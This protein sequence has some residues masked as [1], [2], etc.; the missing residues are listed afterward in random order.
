MDEQH[1]ARRRR[2][3]EAGGPACRDADPGLFFP[4]DGG[5]MTSG[6][7]SRAKALCQACPVQQAC[8]TIAVS[9]GDSNGIWGGTTPGER[10]RLWD[11]AARLR[12]VASIV[13]DLAAGRTVTVAALDRPA[14][15][16][17]LTTAGWATERIAGALGISPATVDA[18]YQRGRSAARFAAAL[19]RGSP[20][21]APGRSAA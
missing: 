1:A 11:Q 7:V 13:T 5:T 6:Q 9:F 17:H 14:V 3:E 2:R 12:S 8:L 16:Y 18:A 10:R 21:K 19:S 15:V 4:P 20:G